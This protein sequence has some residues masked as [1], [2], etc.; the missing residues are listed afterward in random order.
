MSLLYRKDPNDKR[1]KWTDV[2]R[3]LL[4]ILLVYLTFRW[5]LWEP[6]VIPS[7]SMEQTLL[8]QD[9]VTVKKWA[10]GV[11]IPF[12]KNWL[13]GPITPKRGDIVVFKGVDDSGHFL[14]KRVVGLPGDSI[15]IGKTGKIA[16]NGVEF[17]YQKTTSK[18]KNIEENFDVFIEN[19]GD[20]E[21]TVQYL[22]DWDQEPDNYTVPP[23]QLFMMGD[24]RNYSSDSRVWGTLPMANIV[25][26]LS[27]IWVS[28]NESETYSS[29]LCS[30]SDFRL[31]R[32]FKIVK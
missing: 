26:R 12:T 29:F 19:N 4:I 11:R 25:G 21:Y 9:Y 28:C 20:K 30:P 17:N 13:F 27:M 10:Y 24:N 15:Q 6:F 14:V 1:G 3:S 23:G 18:D 7:G 22:K 16:I 31:E 5:I 2:F 32:F 8:V